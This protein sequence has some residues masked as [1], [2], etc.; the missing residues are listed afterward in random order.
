M[1]P[2]DMAEDELLNGDSKSAFNEKPLNDSRE[3]SNYP[4]R[5]MMELVESIAMKQTEIDISDWR[6]W[7][8][9]LEQIL[10]QAK[11]SAIVEVFR[12]IRINPLSPLYHTPFRPM[13]TI[14]NNSDLGN[15]YE[16]TLKRIEC[17]WAVDNLDSIGDQQ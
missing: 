11:D 10:V 8:S 12:K 9:R 3:G 4:V 13:Y 14:A 5:Q 7:C 15:L 1:P 6:L 17:S 2:E 16:E